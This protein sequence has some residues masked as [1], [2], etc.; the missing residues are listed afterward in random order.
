MEFHKVI[1]FS[2][3]STTHIGN[4]LLRGSG[5]TNAGQ[6]CLYKVNQQTT[7]N[8][9]NALRALRSIVRLHR[10]TELKHTPTAQIRPTALISA[11]IVSLSLFTAFSASLS[12][13]AGTTARQAMI[14]VMDSSRCGSAGAI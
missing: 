9:E 6:D 8:T 3:I 12:A 2:I 7:E 1:Q 13:N 4:Q 10:H 5:C 11:K 14:A